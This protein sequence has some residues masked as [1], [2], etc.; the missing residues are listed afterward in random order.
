MSKFLCIKG[1]EAFDEFVAKKEGPLEIFLVPGEDCGEDSEWVKLIPQ[2]SVYSVNP[3]HGR[4]NFVLFEKLVKDLEEGTTPPSSVTFGEGMDSLGS[5]GLVFDDIE[6]EYPSVKVNSEELIN[7]VKEF[8]VVAV[9]DKLE[10][11]LLG[12]FEGTL[13]VNG[14]FFYLNKQPGSVKNAINFGILVAVPEEKISYF[15]E[16]KSTP[17]KGIGKL[18]LLGVSFGELIKTFNIDK[19][20]ASLEEELVKNHSLEESS[21][22]IVRVTTSGLCSMVAMTSNWDDIYNMYLKGVS[23]AKAA[24]EAELETVEEVAVE[25]TGIEEEQQ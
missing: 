15:S 16:E 25:E 10:I 12:E 22:C 19:E 1:L 9:E 7:L 11:D 3:E 8:G 14:I 17:E 18:G 23:Q 24:E 21:C 5:T 20:L 6:A 13:D 2:T 4:V